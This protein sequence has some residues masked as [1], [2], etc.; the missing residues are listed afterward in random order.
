MAVEGLKQSDKKTGEVGETPLNHTQLIHLHSQVL[1]KFEQIWIEGERNEGRWM[2]DNWNQSQRAKI[3]RQKRQAYSLAILASKLRYISATQKQ[4][5]TSFVVEPISDPNDE[6]KA[7]LATLQMRAVENRSNAKYVDSHTFESGLAVKYGVRRV[8]MDTSSIMPRV[9]SYSVDWKNFVWDTNAREYDIKKDALFEAEVEKLPRVYLERIYGKENITGTAGQTHTAFS[10]RNKL[11]YFVNFIKDASEPKPYDMISLFKHCQKTARTFYYVMFQDSAN[12]HSLNSPVIGKYRSSEEAHQVLRELNIS[13]AMHGL[14]EEGEVIERDEVRID[15]YEFTYNKILYYEETEWEMFP[16]DVYFAMK[17]EDKF[18]SYQDFL[19]DPQLIIDRMWAQIDYSLGKDIKNVYQGNR[20]A[21]DSS[22]TA[23]SA[24]R[25][26][27]ETGGIIW[28]KSNEKVFQAIQS[29]GANPQWVNAIQLMVS[30]LEDM[31]GGKTF[32]GG[33]EGK[34]QSGKAIS[35]LQEA[36]S[37]MVSAF[38]DSFNQFKKAHGENILWWIRE[39][40]NEEDT[41][42]VSGGALSP[43][44]RE[45][46]QQDGLFEPSKKGDGTGFVTLNQ[47]GISYLKDAEVELLVRE[48]GMT[49]TM[50]EKRYLQL[51]QAGQDDPLMVQSPTFRRLRL[52]AMDIAHT[53]K[54]KIIEE[55]EKMK[56][57]QE[58]MAQA[59]MQM[60]AEKN[61]MQ[62]G[63]DPL[64]QAKVVSDIRAQEQQALQ[65][66][67]A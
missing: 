50:R 43:E 59:Q 42:K 53:D 58:Q 28:T 56:Q 65:G 45:L 16:Y 8:G 19:N 21:L 48:E 47:G 15:Y 26:A 4:L 3:R 49:E 20:K 41:I 38:L 7:Q 34:T 61:K 11:S 57:Q 63:K 2:G 52:E 35:K 29:Q 55:T 62:Y 17:F 32:K 31:T 64:D 1:P 40:E 5:R 25:K 12:Q 54:E 14:P 24:E 39:Y 30:Y 10:G 36:G 33:A 60:E 51:T 67:E 23:Q 37:V 44:M 13:N 27:S 9:K 46:L 6:I 66:A 22:E 18:A